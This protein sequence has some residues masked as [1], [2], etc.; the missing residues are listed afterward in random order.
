MTS[1]PLSSK[2][3]MDPTQ[4]HTYASL[5]PQIRSD[6]LSEPPVM[7]Q[8]RE[9]H[10]PSDDHSYAELSGVPTEPYKHDSDSQ[11]NIVTTGGKLFISSSDKVEISVEYQCENTLPEATKRSTTTEMTGSE[12]W[13]SSKSTLNEPRNVS[14]E[15]NNVNNP[16]KEL[17]DDTTSSEDVLLDET[18][19]K[20]VITDPNKTTSDVLP[21]DTVSENKVLSDETENNDSVNT[22]EQQLTV[23]N[24]TS[25]DVYPDTTATASTLHEATD[26]TSNNLSAETLSSEDVGTKKENNITN[27]TTNENIMEVYLYATTDMLLDETMRPSSP[28]PDATLHTNLQ[29][30]EN[31]ISTT[32]ESKE[33][34]HVDLD[35][36]E[37][38]KPLDTERQEELTT[39]LMEN[40]EIDTTRENVIGE[41]TFTETDTTMSNTNGNKESKDILTLGDIP[42]GV[43]GMHP[44]ETSSVIPKPTEGGAVVELTPSTSISTSSS[45]FNKLTPI[46]KKEETRFAKKNRLKQCIIK[47]TEL[48]NSDRE[49]WLSGESSSSWSNRTTESIESSDSSG[50]RYNMRSRPNSTCKCPVRTTRPKINYTEHRMKDSSHDSDFEPVLKP[51]TP[52]DNKSHPTPSRI[53]MQKEIELNKAT[54]RNHMT[55]FPDKSQLRNKNN[56]ATGVVNKAVKPNAPNTPRSH[57]P[58]RD[59]TNT[60]TTN[61]LP[62]ATK[63]VLPDIMDKDKDLPDTTDKNTM[64]NGKPTKG[65]FK[66]KQISIRR[67]KD[68]RTFKCSK[69]DTHASSLKELNAHFIETHHQVNCDICGKGFNTP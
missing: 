62:E 56:K 46:T 21:D 12:Q 48:S 9:Q 4:D 19:N 1:T 67:S 33:S 38:V 36:N 31:I 41:I 43:S 65:I 61:E 58:V 52:L 37:P 64:E 34:E 11:D 28:L 25:T 5:A 59:A 13:E 20:S 3:G 16:A 39:N 6:V 49:K 69:C 51:L 10:P 63:N 30:P 47:L 68:P 35:T 60:P 42:Q 24:T 2:Q 14:D 57:S 22:G 7:D 45:S 32:H 29:M 55:A 17:P 8:I 15:T 18:A 54:K 50:S 44:V 66:T 26:I 40:T 53:T 23:S 27:S